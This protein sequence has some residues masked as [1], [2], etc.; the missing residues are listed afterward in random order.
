MSLSPAELERQIEAL[1]AESALEYHEPFRGQ[2]IRLLNG[3]PAFEEIEI[4]WE[5]LDRRRQ[6]EYEKLNAIQSYVGAGGCRREWIVGYFGQKTLETAHCQCDRCEGDGIDAPRTLIRPGAEAEGY[7]PEEAAS[8]MAVLRCAEETP[9]P[10]GLKKLAQ[11]ASGTQARWALDS[12]MDDLP[13]YGAANLQ[14]ARVEAIAER[15]A[16][17]GFFRLSPGKY[18]TAKLTPAGEALLAGQAQLPPRADWLAAAPAGDGRDAQEPKPA[19][20]MSES[21]LFH[22]LRELRAAEAKRRRTQAFKILSDGALRHMA[23]LRPASSAELASIKGIGPEKLKKFGGLFLEEIRRLT[24]GAPARPAESLDSALLADSAPPA[25]VAP[26]AACPCSVSAESPPPM[27]DPAA[28]LRDLIHFFL[29]AERE[30][31]QEA[32]RRLKLFD[33]TAIWNGMEAAWERAADERSRTRLIWA[34][35]EIG[36]EGAERWLV[37]RLAEPS[38]V[39]RRLA[40]ESLRKRPGRQTEAALVEALLDRDEAVQASAAAALGEIGGRPAQAALDRMRG[41]KAIGGTAADAIE[42]A[43]SRIARRTR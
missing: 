10:L 24:E 21:E 1:A 9:W 34:A 22:A 30:E 3:K 8:A 33:R 11:L 2:G 18:P 23:K 28:V 17:D 4:D 42:D 13:S 12:S 27:P 37:A 36:A 6:A 5:S 19:K 43:I 39:E 40:C 31:A 20:P 32:F 26:C 38:P 25:A 29:A 41:S 14:Q 35:G 16:R 7:G 15:L